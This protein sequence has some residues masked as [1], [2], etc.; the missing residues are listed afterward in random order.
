MLLTYATAGRNS[1][2]KQAKQIN[3]RTGLCFHAKKQQRQSASAV[4][5]KVTKTES[6]LSCILLRILCFSVYK[7][8]CLRALAK[9]AN[10]K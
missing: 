4:P 5:I 8:N 7:S 10:T 6:E 9:E 3:A 2:R 1:A